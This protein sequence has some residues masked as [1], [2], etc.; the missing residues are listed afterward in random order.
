MKQKLK[1]KLKSDESKNKL[2]KNQKVFIIKNETFYNKL[3]S[4][5]RIY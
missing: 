4:I 5:K 3:K 1:I 2:L